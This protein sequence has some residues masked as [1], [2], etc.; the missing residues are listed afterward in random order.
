MSTVEDRLRETLA[1]RAAQTSVDPDAWNKAVARSRRRLLPWHWP[2]WA[3]RLAPVAAVVAVA[4]VVISA[5]MLGQ[6]VGQGASPAGPSTANPSTS[7]N[8]SWPG[9]MA[10]AV[11][12]IPPVTPFVSLSLRADGIQTRSS[13]WFGYVPGHKAAGLALCQYYSKDGFYT[14]YI[15]CGYGGLPKGTLARQAGT[16]GTAWIHM[17]V[18]VPQASSVTAL[19]PGGK[20]AQG[21]VRSA[22]GVADKIWAVSFKVDSAATLVFRDAAG[23]QVTRLNV[24]KTPPTPSR[25]STGGIPLFLYGNGPLWAYRTSGDRIVYWFD[26]GSSWSDIPLS[27][28]KLSWSGTGGFKS[29]TKTLPNVMFGYAPT[30]TARAGLQLADGRRFTAGTISAWPG[31]GLVF[32]GPV[33]LPARTSLDFDSVL[34][35]YDSAGHILREVPIIFIQ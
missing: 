7:P 27:Q 13:L 29:S 35:T 12:Q 4:G 9:T 34:V 26:G 11:R 21:T 20:T 23:H 6:S 3:V 22:R 30:G 24:P 5:T 10:A 32:W 17:G 25:P 15:G 2:T 16:D 19:L 33:S 14:G 28:S 8:A 18:T 1:E 31:S